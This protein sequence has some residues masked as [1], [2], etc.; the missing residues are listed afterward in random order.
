MRLLYLLSIAV[1]SATALAQM[2]QGGPP[3][4]GGKVREQA[5]DSGRRAARSGAVATPGLK[6]KC[7]CQ[8]AVQMSRRSRRHGA[9]VPPSSRY[10]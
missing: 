5:A 1:A 2:P 6:G 7:A 10:L 8:D 3:P 4:A 9:Q